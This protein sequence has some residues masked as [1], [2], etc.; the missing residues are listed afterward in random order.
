MHSWRRICKQINQK[1]NKARKHF[2]IRV[3]GLRGCL[4]DASGDLGAHNPFSKNQSSPNT[5][6][7]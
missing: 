3:W 2:L 5:Q 6:R 1:K 4:A 7:A